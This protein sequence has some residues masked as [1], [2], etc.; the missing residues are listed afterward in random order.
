MARRLFIA[1]ACARLW[2]VS[3]HRALTRIESELALAHLSLIPT[4]SGKSFRQVRGGCG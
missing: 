3:P 2:R 1:L 4:T